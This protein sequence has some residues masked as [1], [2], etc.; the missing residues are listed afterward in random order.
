MKHITIIGLF[1]CLCSC[2][3]KKSSFATEHE[4]KPIPTLDLIALDSTT[5]INTKTWGNGK[6]VILMDFSPFCSYSR[7]MTQNLVDDN[8]KVSDI[9]IILLS[10]FPIYELKNFSK[11]YQ[12]G[13]YANVTLAWDKDGSFGKYFNTPGVPC[14]AIYGK[15]KKL[16]EVLLGQ[17]KASLIKDIAEE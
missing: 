10:S 5:H 4:G 9:Q 13:K 8:T 17:V 3:G 1:C 16:R 12:L 14:I 7:A 6:A 15:D 2:Y 11:E